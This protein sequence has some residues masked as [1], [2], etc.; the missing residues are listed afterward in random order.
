MN[1][2]RLLTLYRRSTALVDVLEDGAKDDRNYH[3]RAWWTRLLTA[4]AGL[5]AVVPVAARERTIMSQWL[6][7]IG[8]VIGSAAVVVGAIDPHALATV[9]PQAAAIVTVAGSI[10]AT[11]AGIFHQAPGAT[12]Q[13]PK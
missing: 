1:P 4:A 7:K 5:Y 9:S 8:I 12:D 11:L 10:I 13:P 6:H 3:S 2:L